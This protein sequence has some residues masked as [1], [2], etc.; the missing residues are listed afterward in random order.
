MAAVSR[1]R[2]DGP[3]GRE[4]ASM[5][6][7][8]AAAVAVRDEADDAGGTAVGPGSLAPAF[9]AVVPVVGASVSPAEST[10]GVSSRLGAGAG[11]SS[12]EGSRID[13]SMGRSAS[14]AVAAGVG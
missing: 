13:S 11:V 14:G 3:I 10:R 4:T 7:A 8:R 2:R 6:G 5:T 12:G 9:G 1:D